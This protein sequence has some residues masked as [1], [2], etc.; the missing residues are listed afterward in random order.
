[1]SSSSGCD[2]AEHERPTERKIDVV[3]LGLKFAGC[4]LGKKEVI[5]L[6]S[7]FLCVTSIVES[8][9]RESSMLW[10]SD[11]WALRV[12]TGMV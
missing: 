12:K 11:G 7:C 2:D 1:M 8:V 9:L 5:G 4:V 10:K 6:S 3:G